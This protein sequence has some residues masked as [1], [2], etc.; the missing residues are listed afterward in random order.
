MND[1]TRMTAPR[2]MRL[3]VAAAGGII[4]AVAGCGGA[5]TPV[6]EVPG[7]PPDEDTMGVA[8][9]MPSTAPAE[10]HACGSSNGCNAG[11]MR[12][13]D[14]GAPPASPAGPSKP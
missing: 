4:A 8:A 11:A 9:P 13:K 7:A 14:P 3:A 12:G 2:S 6:P 5:Q 1:T 10:K